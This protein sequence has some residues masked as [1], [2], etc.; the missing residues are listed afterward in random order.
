MK[1]SVRRLKS[2]KMKKGEGTENT[3]S[4]KMSVKRGLGKNARRGGAQPRTLW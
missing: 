2:V 1:N 4:I 3:K